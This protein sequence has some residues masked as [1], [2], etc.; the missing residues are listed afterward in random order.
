[1]SADV[2]R[3]ADLPRCWVAILTD[4]IKKKR[5]LKTIESLKPHHCSLWAHTHWDLI[6]PLHSKVIGHRRHWE[7]SAETL[8]LEQEKKAPSSQKSSA[9]LHFS[10]T[11]KIH[12]SQPRFHYCHA[13]VTQII[14]GTGMQRAEVCY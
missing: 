10:F 3:N 11:V 6:A 8:L 13:D 1:V 7:T 5:D 2:L 12:L 9:N 14:M 4:A